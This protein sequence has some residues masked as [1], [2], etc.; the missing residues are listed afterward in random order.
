V[1]LRHLAIA[2]ED[3]RYQLRLAQQAFDVRRA[4]AGIP[5]DDAIAAAVEARREAERHVH[6]QRQITRDRLVV[7]A[8]CVA[9]EIRLGEIRAEL[10]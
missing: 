10:R 1:D 6:I 7:G 9:A 8:P 4:T 5:R 3:L 2:V